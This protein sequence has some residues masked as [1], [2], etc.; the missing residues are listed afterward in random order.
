M[1]KPTPIKKLQADIADLQ[2]AFQMMTQDT[3]S[4]LAK[5]EIQLGS[6]EAR[7]LSLEDRFGRIEAPLSRL[8]ATIDQFIHA[9]GEDNATVLGKIARLEEQIQQNRPLWK[10]LF[11]GQGE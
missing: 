6:A 8:E 10:R 2:T 4:R 7:I 5:L 3:A 11:G 9:Q 1:K